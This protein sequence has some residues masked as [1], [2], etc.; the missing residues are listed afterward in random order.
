MEDGS[1]SEQQDF[2]IFNNRF[3]EYNSSSFFT[4]TLM[5][6]LWS[7]KILSLLVRLL[8]G[9]ERWVC[10]TEQE[11]E[12]DSAENNE[13]FS[14]DDKHVQEQFQSQPSFFTELNEVLTRELSEDGYSCN[15]IFPL[16]D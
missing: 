15:I 1:S 2:V 6:L 4:L 5:D 7:K 16:I 10:F 9:E 13:F 11:E 14:T 3:L 12:V 8:A